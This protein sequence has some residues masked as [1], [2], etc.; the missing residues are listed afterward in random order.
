MLSQQSKVE[1][2]LI[3]LSFT[4]FLILNII[5]WKFPFF[6]DTLL[7]ST[8]TQ[9]FFSNGY[10]NFIPPNEYD[11]GHPPLFYIYLS[12]WWKLLGKSLLVSHFAMLP[13]LWL[14]VYQFIKIAT[15]FLNHYNYIMIATLFFCL[16]PTILSQSTLVSYDI[17]LLAFYLSA[18]RGILFNKRTLLAISLIV[19]SLTSIR[20]TIS[21]FALLTT[22]LF[23]SKVGVKTFSKKYLIAYLPSILLTILWHLYH[24]V[25]VDWMLFSPSSKWEDQ[26]VI[27]GIEL[28]LKNIL[29]IG[30]NLFDYGRIGLW[31]VLIAMMSFSF[32]KKVPLQK[33]EKALLIC[34]LCPIIIFALAFI[35]FSNPIGHRYFLIVYALLIICCVHFIALKAMKFLQI[36]L[37]IIG[38]LLFSGNFWVYNKIS[39]G[40][41]ST[42]AHIPYFSVQKK[43][44]AFINENNIPKKEIA[45]KFPLNVS[46]QQTHLID[47]F[48]KPQF[49]EEGK[50]NTQSYVL[51]SNISNDFS[52]SEKEILKDWEVLQHIKRGSVFM[53]I[54]SNPSIPE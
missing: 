48:S 43:M 20:G 3:P 27:V 1:Q 23:L 41:D 53:T 26:R 30:R 10:G 13:F 17:V 14:M 49:L 32:L 2:L 51:Y 12:L 22:E 37:V 19:L 7:T 11:A 4:F 38:I 42:M 21:I 24:Y 18:L 45:S 16:E 29:I 8:N 35:P 15:Y 39:N 47:D 50:I 6:W 46:R 33:N 31:L 36:L 9:W 5:S 34:F 28:L 40:W 25:Q 44:E 54:Y 52:E